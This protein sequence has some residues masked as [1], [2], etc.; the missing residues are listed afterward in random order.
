[1]PKTSRAAREMDQRLEPLGDRV[2]VCPQEP[3]KMTPGGLHLPERRNPE[4]DRPERGTVV[5][6]GPDVKQVQKGDQ[7]LVPRY[8]GT[9]FELDGQRLWAYKEEAILAK[10]VP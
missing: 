10:L 9:E 8:G 2:V 4:I 5:A 7:V 1:M 6:A 3:E